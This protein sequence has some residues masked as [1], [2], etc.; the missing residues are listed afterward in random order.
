MT[1]VAQARQA[2]SPGPTAPLSRA[3]GQSERVQGKVERAASDLASVNTVLKTEI[4]EAVPLGKVERALNQSEAVEVKVQEASEELATVNQALGEEVR[5]RHI[6]EKRLHD[7]D[8]ALA[9]SQADEKR[10]L[11]SS[12]H[13]PVTGLA[14]LTLFTD[15]L[16]NAIAQAQR[17]DWRLAVL[18]ID[19]D[20]FKAVN[21]THGHDAGDRV[22]NMVAQRLQ[23]SVR[24]GDTVSRRSG[25]EFLLLMLE[26]KNEP[27]VAVFA[28]KI[29]AKIAETSDLGGSALSQ[30]SM[31]ASI[32][33]ALYPEDGRTPEQLLKNADL[34][35][36]T[37][38]QKKAGPALF[39]QTAPG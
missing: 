26:A 38:K 33:I 25:D 3:L 15:R 1:R 8:R 6:L 20:E 34:A 31:K 13:D 35:M 2:E 16:S 28:D 37:A 39:S 32:G 14:N 22:L 29:L 30:L 12:L 18:F 10:A 11:H 21:D 24:A 23:A 5:E 7:S 19:L 17:H 27:N 9:R 36:Y 4:P